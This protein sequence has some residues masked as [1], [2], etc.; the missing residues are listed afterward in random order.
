M[1]GELARGGFI[2][3][4]AIAARDQL[5]HPIMQQ[6]ARNIAQMDFFCRS[7]TT[8]CSAE[9]RQDGRRRGGRHRAAGSMTGRQAMAALERARAQ[10][11][12]E[13]S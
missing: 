6:A 1:A 12:R 10:D 11:A 2:V 7:A 8:P 9:R 4:A 5:G 13:G 3:P